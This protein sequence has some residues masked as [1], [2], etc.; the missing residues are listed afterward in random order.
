MTPALIH[1]QVGAGPSGLIMALSLI[2][3]G[4][5][6]RIIDKNQS[7]RLGSRGFGVQ[8][9]S[10]PVYLACILNSGLGSLATHF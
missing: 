6:V 4:V 3:S 8:V 10:L 9:A 1:S 5:Q 7:F 2:Q